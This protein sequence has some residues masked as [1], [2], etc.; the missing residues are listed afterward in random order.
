MSISATI[1]IMSVHD[2]SPAPSH[3]VNGTIWWDV[4][5]LRPM[6]SFAETQQRPSH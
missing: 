1:S 4:P 5:P 2:L 6:L 3:R